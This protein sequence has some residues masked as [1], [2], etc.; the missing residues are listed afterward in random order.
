LIL[1]QAIEEVS[2]ARVDA[3]QVKRERTSFFETISMCFNFLQF[4]RLFEEE[5]LKGTRLKEQVQPA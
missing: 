3:V 1:F 2:S 5:E 4:R